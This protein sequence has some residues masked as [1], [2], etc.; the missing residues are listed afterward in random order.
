MDKTKLTK[1]DYNNEPVHF[2]KQCLSLA[3]IEDNQLVYCEKCGNTSLGEEHV[4]HWKRLYKFRYGEE[5]INNIKRKSYE[6]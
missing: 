6:R 4:E 3:I 5:Y 1:E 2:C